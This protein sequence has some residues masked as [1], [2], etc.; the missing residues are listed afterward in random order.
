MQIHPRQ[1]NKLNYQRAL[2]SRYEH[3][4]EIRRI[5]KHQR[6]PKTIK[7]ARDQK[8][9]HLMAKRRR[10]ENRRRVSKKEI[11]RVPATKKP[12]AGVLF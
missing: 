6:V 8:R 4:H 11:P 7:V 3:L 9:E 12:V 10:E 5:V 1:R 2:I